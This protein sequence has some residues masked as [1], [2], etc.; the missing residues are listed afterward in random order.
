MSPLIRYNGR[1]PTQLMILNFSI[2]MFRH[3]LKHTCIQR[4]I[5]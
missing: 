1:I 5:L 2:L 3:S 4:L